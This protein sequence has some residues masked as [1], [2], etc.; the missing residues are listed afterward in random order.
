MAAARHTAAFGRPR[1]GRDRRSGALVHELEHVRRGD[2]AVH[3]AARVAGTVFWFHPLV[4]IA[5]RRMCL[6]AERAC[7]DAVLLRAE[8]TGYASQLVQLARRMTKL[9]LHPT[10][11]MASRSDL[12]ARVSAILDTAQARGRLHTASVVTGLL[13]AVVL[14]L[15]IAPLRAVGVGGHSPSAPTM[16]G[17]DAPRDQPGRSEGVADGGLAS[18]QVPRERRETS[19]RLIE[20]L[21]RALFEAAEDGSLSDISELLAAG[22]NVNAALAGDGSPIIGAARTGRLAAV[23][24]LLERGADPGVV[25]RGDGS[26][27]IMAAREGHVEIVEVLLDRGAD[28]EQVA[29]GDENALIQ[30]SA[31]GHLSVVELLVARGANVNTR[32]WAERSSFFGASGEWRTPLS[33]AERGGH[34]DVVAYLRSAGAEE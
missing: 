30:A 7:D 1:V 27:L 19:R 18:S 6:E 12:A 25:V 29:P 5:F 2:W 13:A 26:P 34:D 4:W 16:Q 11:G 9:R 17:V 28:I 14:A 32:V 10:V 22:G 24:L 20:A 23:E 15:A 31:R 3:L 21:D 33:M 8:S